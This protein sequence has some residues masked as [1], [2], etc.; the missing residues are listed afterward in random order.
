MKAVGAIRAGE[1]DEQIGKDHV[2]VP[3]QIPEPIEQPQEVPE[4]EAVPEPVPVEVE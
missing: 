3:R 4:R 1:L 2:E